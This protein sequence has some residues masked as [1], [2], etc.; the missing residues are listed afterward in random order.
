M[1]TEPLAAELVH[2]ARRNGA[3]V[4]DCVTRTCKLEGLAGPR[5]KGTE[6]VGCRHAT[7]EA[8]EKRFGSS[9]SERGEGPQQPCDEVT[10]KVLR[11][12]R[13]SGITCQKRFPTASAGLSA[14]RSRPPATPVTARKMPCCRREP[15]ST[16]INPWKLQTHEAGASAPYESLKFHENERWAVRTRTEEAPL[17]ARGAPRLYS[18]TGKPPSKN[19]DPVAAPEAVTAHRC[20]FGQSPKAFRL[21]D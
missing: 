19:R 6:R 16:A 17:T 10:A 4:C 20:Q 1:D 5:E 15:N 9:Q 11:R 13:L 12:L 14:N 21:T 18:H 8:A 3:A 7:S 2:K